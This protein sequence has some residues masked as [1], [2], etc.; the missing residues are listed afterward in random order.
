MSWFSDLFSDV[1]A[2]DVIQPIATAW[3]ANRGRQIA[4]QG[5]AAAL[6]AMQQRNAQALQLAREG[7]AASNARLEQVQQQGQ[8]GITH[9]QNVVAQDPNQLSD[10][11]KITRDDKAREL[12]ARLAKSGLRGAGRSVAAVFNDTMNRSDAAMKAE[13]QGRSDRA[14][15]ALAAPAISAQ[16]AAAGNV[17]QGN[18]Y[19]AGLVNQMGQSEGS[20]ITS[21]AAVEAQ[22][23]GNI[24]GSV[25]ARD[26]SRASRYSTTLPR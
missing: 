23:V 19:A 21:N 10:A 9:L 12:N 16:T 8:P 22:T 5:N 2:S 6:Q 17:N 15:T 20:A 4:Q 3:G 25:L 11:Q 24:L 7:M 1:K 26:D 13:N 14:A 18:Q